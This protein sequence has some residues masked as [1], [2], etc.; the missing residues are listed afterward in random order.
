MKDEE[1]IY[2]NCA[3]CGEGII[4]DQPPYPN[5]IGP[6]E[7]PHCQVRLLVNISDGKVQSCKE[8]KV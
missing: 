8:L 5:Y 7:C 3:V 6:I 1:K 4:L 2:F